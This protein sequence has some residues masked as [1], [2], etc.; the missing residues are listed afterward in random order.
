MK[1]RRDLFKIFY[2]EHNLSRYNFAEN[3][4]VKGARRTRGTRTL[5]SPEAQGAK[6]NERQIEVRS[7]HIKNI[8]VY[9]WYMIENHRQIE[10]LKS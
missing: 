6:K 8:Y 9:I 10:S 7:T 4:C 3:Q 2:Q 5:I 1:P